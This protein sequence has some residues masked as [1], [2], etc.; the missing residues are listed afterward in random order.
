MVMRIDHIGIAVRSIDESLKIYRDALG[1]RVDRIQEHEI[2]NVRLAMLPVGESNIE[3]LEST[4]PNGAIAKFI[5]QNGEC[6]HHIAFE[7]SDIKSSI[8]RLKGK[9]YRFIKTLKEQ[10]A[11]V[12]DIEPIKGFSAPKIVFLDPQ[13]TKVILELVERN[14]S[15]Q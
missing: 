14:G 9:G 13:K 10:D 3:L 1:M 6:I 12:S 11:P 5:E 8:E 7:V 4:D 15:D 2:N